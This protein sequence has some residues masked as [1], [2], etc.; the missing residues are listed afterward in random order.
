MTTR[1]YEAMFILENNAAT[2][3]F[4]GTAGKVDEILQKHGANLV[5]KD[6]WDE[7]KLAYEIKGHRRGTYY[8]VY[9]EAPPSSITAMNE[10]LGLTETVLRH[11]VIALDL[12][13]DDYIDKRAAERERLAE[14]SRKNAI[15]GWGSGPRRGG[16]GPEPRKPR[17]VA[18]G[19]KPA[20]PVKA[21]PAKAEETKAEPAKAEP[22]KAEE[23]KAEPAKAEEAK[24]EP[25]KAEE[26]KAEPAKAE[27]A[28]PESATTDGKEETKTKEETAPKP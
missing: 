4:E 21:E 5:R 11:M 26:A 25:A 6:K 1:N 16:R 13:I 27:E 19:D 7:R 20:E 23:A 10:D 2:A 3:D 8:L 15:G 18:E 17:P 28:K 14:D 24:A 9:F 12:P 22:A